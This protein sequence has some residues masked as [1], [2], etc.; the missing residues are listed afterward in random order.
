MRARITGTGRY[1]PSEVWTSERVEARVCAESSGFRFP[2]GVVQLASGVAERRF[3]PE[4]VNS[5]D[6][7]VHA[8]KRALRA[9]ERDSLEID[10]LIFASASH[11][12][13]EPATANIVQA[14]LGCERAAVMDVKNAC[15]SF[16]NGLDVAHAF[17]ETGRATRVLVVAGERLSTTI[18]WDL[19]ESDDLS[20]R[21]AA[22]TLGDAGA[23]MVIE[24]SGDP[25]R[26]LLPG[27]FESDGRFWAL[28]T[29]L[30]GGSRY[31]ASPEQMYFVCESSE[32]QKLAVNRLPPLITDTLIKL[33]WALE[34]IALVVPHQ[35]SAAVIDRLCTLMS[36]PRERCMM[37]LHRLG[38]TAAAS[39]PAAFDT[40]IEEGRVKPGDKVLLVGGAAGFSA[41]VVPVVL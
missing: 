23:A 25:E 13:A 35:V 32:L 1:E 28:S 21:L 16:L 41:G 20:T 26:G 34:D 22:L 6:L 11:D 8:A 3:A 15:N 30:A 29:V 27:A 17:I 10:L 40:A 7:A 4:G 5:S 38:N 37:T 24:A 18:K 33:D 12:V 2:R 31:G 39:I 19:D 14:E 9:A 36:Y